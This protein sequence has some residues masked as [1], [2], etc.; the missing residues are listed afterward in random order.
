MPHIPY[1]YE[2]NWHIG[3]RKWFLNINLF[4][5]N[6]KQSLN[7]LDQ[8]DLDQDPVF[9]DYIS[10]SFLFSHSLFRMSVK[11]ILSDLNDP[12]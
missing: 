7:V 4:L 3:H 12:D 2:V 11:K 10:K 5:I 6:I 1:P 8:R 9:F